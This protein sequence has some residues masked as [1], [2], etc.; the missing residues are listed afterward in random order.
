MSQK[1]NLNKIKLKYKR[2]YK[3]VVWILPSLFGLLLLS[4]YPRLQIFPMSLYKWSPVSSIKE[5]KGLHYYKMMFQYNIDN[6]L[7]YA[8]NTIMYIF[9]LFAIQT[10]L[11]F[12]LAL[13][14]QKN[15]KHNRIFRAFFFLP[16]V[17]SSTMISLTWAYMYDPNLGIINALLGKL[18]VDGFPGFSFFQKNWMAVLCIVIV[19]IWA[20]IGYPITILTSGLNTI[21]EEVMEASR[22]DG[23]NAWQSFWKITFPLML[24][25]AL[26]LSLLTVSTGAMASDYIVMIGSRSMEKDYDTWAAVLYKGVLNSTD[27]GSLCAKCVVMFF[28]LA[29]FSL[30]QY[31]ALRKVENAVL[32]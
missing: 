13:A 32:G 28:V 16:M 26:R 12:L 21:S 30:I 3:Y 31:L 20:N 14:L 6:T 1:V 11:S 7:L 17:F 15:T 23:A 24:P 2:K 8:K 18:S 27:Y 29:V 4:V 5:Y 25:T 22:I 10:V 19:H 9:F